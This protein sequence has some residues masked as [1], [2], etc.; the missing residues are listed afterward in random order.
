MAENLLLFDLDNTLLSTSDLDGFRG[1]A[2]LGAQPNSYVRD[3]LGAYR[4]RS[5]VIYSIETLI[6]LR[7]RF[8]AK[9]GVFTRSPRT[10]AETLL[11]QA[12]PTLT[13]DALIAFEDVARTKPS[14]DG[15]A[16]A[17]LLTGISDRA[18]VALIGDELVDICAAYHGGCWSILDQ[19]SWPSTKEKK[20]Y[21]AL[22]RNPDAVIRTPSELTDALDSLFENLPELE[23]RC[24]NNTNKK[25]GRPIFHKHGYFNPLTPEV[26][27]PVWVHYLGRFFTQE[28]HQRAC[29]HQLT[30][31]ILQHKS[32][33]MFPP[34]W[35]DSI[36][37]FLE[38][39]PPPKAAHPIVVTVIPAKPGRVARLEALL[40]QLSKGQSNPLITFAPSLL[41]FSQGVRS[42]NSEHLNKNERFENI[43]DH[44]QVIAPTE[45]R[46]KH[47]V[48]IDDVITT[49]ASLLVAK[50]RLE[51]AGA[52]EVTCLSIAK[53]ING[54]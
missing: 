48:V 51:E 45:V 36:L 26:N 15:I 49:G 11:T 31:E 27:R 17:Q 16:R 35:I 29:W 12:Y 5:R 3:L 32:S 33:T 24:S 41:G 43:R 9:L 1:R 7:K 34:H 14:G 13:W 22:E 46:S 50:Q 28:V 18:S 30:Q 40:Q 20:H 25:N 44:L 37:A 42:H 47:I 53:T 2:Y 19:S 6:A 38:G 8:D 4:Q 23:R 54:K 10:Y 21:W 52:R 39:L